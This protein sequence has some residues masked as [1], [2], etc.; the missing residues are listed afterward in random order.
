MGAD[1]LPRA[2]TRVAIERMA[3]KLEHSLREA[4]RHDLVDDLAVDAHQLDECLE[5]WRLPFSLQIGFPET[6]LSR[7]QEAPCEIVVL[8]HELGLRARRAAVEMHLA[9]VRQDGCERSG[10]QTRGRPENLAHE[11]RHIGRKRLLRAVGHVRSSAPRHRITQAVQ[12]IKGAAPTTKQPR[13]ARQRTLRL[14]AN[15]ASALLRILAHPRFS[16][17]AT[18]SIPAPRQIDR[19]A[20]LSNA[21]GA[22]RVARSSAGASAF[23][24]AENQ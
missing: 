23:V 5:A 11:V 4:P 17:D 2:G 22:L 19:D 10:A 20:W 1:V 9:S 15:S 18:R 16:P 3:E 24:E 12:G 8:D 6:E 14:R 21:L 13:C 7:R